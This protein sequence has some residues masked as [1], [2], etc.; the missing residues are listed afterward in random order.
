MRDRR[1]YVVPKLLH[2]LVERNVQ[3]A[4]RAVSCRTRD[5]SSVTLHVTVV[6]R[7]PYAMQ[8]RIHTAARDGERA[9]PYH[10]H[11][12]S[13]SPYSLMYGLFDQLIIVHL[14]L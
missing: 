11:S 6:C 14:F 7:E 10:T 9:H 3:S 4:A 2:I 13:L 1:M 5:A 12:L 8:Q